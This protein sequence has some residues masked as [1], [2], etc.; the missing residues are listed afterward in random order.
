MPFIK[1]KELEF[2]YGNKKW[3]SNGEDAQLLQQLIRTNTINLDKDS[4]FDICKNYPQFR[5]Y[6]INNFRS[7]IYRYKTKGKDNKIK[8]NQS[9]DDNN[10]T[11]NNYNINKDILNG[12]YL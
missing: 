7:V 10:N 5:S 3:E 8:I 2:E 6:P 12:T 1:T 11:N 9:T 4:A